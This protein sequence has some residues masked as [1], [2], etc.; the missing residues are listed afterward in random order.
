[1]NYRQIINDIKLGICAINIKWTYFNIYEICKIIKIA[2]KNFVELTYEGQL[3]RLR[4]LI[5]Y[6]PEK[7][8]KLINLAFYEIYISKEE[9]NIN[10]RL[11][12]SNVKI[13][14]KIIRLYIMYHVSYNVRNT[15]KR[16]NSLGSRIITNGKVISY[17]VDKYKTQCPK[18]NV[19]VQNL[20]NDIFVRF[21]ILLYVY[22]TYNN[23]KK[24]CTNTTDLTYLTKILQ[25]DL[26]KE[27]M[28]R[29]ETFTSTELS[30]FN[31]RIIHMNIY[32]NISNSDYTQ[33]IMKNIKYTH[34]NDFSWILYNSSF[35]G[36]ADNL[37]LYGE[38]K[39]KLIEFILTKH[40]CLNHIFLSRV[41]I[42]TN[43]L[44]LLDKKVLE[45]YNKFI[46]DELK[47][48]IIKNNGIIDYENGYIYRMILQTI[49]LPTCLNTKKL[50]I[51]EELINR[52]TYHLNVVPFYEIECINGNI[53]YVDFVNI[54]KKYA[55]V[56]IN[57]KEHK[58]LNNSFKH[59]MDILINK[60]FKKIYL[61]RY[62]NTNAIINNPKKFVCYNHHGNG[63]IYYAYSDTNY[64]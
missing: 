35:A 41:L 15:I 51:S 47:Q 28:R 10:W 33:Q 21:C 3:S 16:Y 11:S 53:I 52:Y 9:T 31:N 24:N 30:M 7:Q 55:Y 26:A 8:Q 14:K 45:V 25:I 18:F 48:F 19:F 27:F 36:Y 13:N 1:M 49:S 38:F 57:T 39:N 6:L 37:L 56:L 54:N 61:I 62:L 32:N 46:Y 44:N 2:N 12:S 5:N 29:Y 23:D 58:I 40:H 17:V 4:N 42:R 43:C 64:Y 22:S 34:M 20:D 63:K 50:L 60:G 59:Y